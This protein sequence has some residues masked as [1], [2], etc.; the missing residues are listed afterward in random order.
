[1][2]SGSGDPGHIDFLDRHLFAFQEFSGLFKQ[3]LGIFSVQPDSLNLFF[4]DHRLHPDDG[5]GLGTGQ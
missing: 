3:G 2:L 1:M 4:A 5:A